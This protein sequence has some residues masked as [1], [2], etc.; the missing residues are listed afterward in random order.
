[1][2]T[3]LERIAEIAKNSPKEKFTSLIHLINK[4]MLI[5]CHN[6]LSG[7]KATGVDKLTKK[8]YEMNL[9]GNIE[10]LIARMK[11]FKY[12]PQ[13]VRRVYIDKPGSNKKRPLGI[14][15]HEDKIVQLAINKIL[16][17][18]YEQDFIDS[19]FGFRPN[20]SCHDAL[21]ILNVYLSEKDINY[22]VD[23]DIK[24]FFDNVDH[25][26]MMKFLEH[27]ISDKN[28]LRY[29]GR[30]L[31]TGIMENGTYHKVEEGT[32]Q[33]GIISPTLANIYL[34]YVLD[35]WFNNFI[36]KRCKGQAYIV[37]Y[38]DDFV[39]CFQ[40]ENEA[41][42]FYE[43]LKK[44][45]DKFNLQVAE[46]KTKILYFGKKSFYDRKFKRVWKLEDYTDRTF[47]FLGFTHYCSTRKDGSFRVK[48]KTSSKKFRAS[49]KKMSEWLKSNRTLPL[50]LLMKKLKQ[51]LIG[52]YRYYG[53]T[54][55]SRELKKFR[56]YVKKLTFKWLNKRSQ[57]RSYTW[58]NFDK[59]FKF[60]DIPEA[61]IYVNIFGLRKDIAYIL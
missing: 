10:N 3:K 34:H 36:K 11:A 54:D 37:R 16:Q 40:F 51:K 42:A 15:A 22:V 52:H 18:I 9:E 48:R 43:V 21:K 60:F 32:P 45:L 41:K 57:K 12:R 8:E 46:D 14:P 23:A 61:K 26:W 53:I 28:L 56:Y 58:V 33:G 13:P 2:Y 25:K 49:I 17:S 31:K 55:N 38:A 19:S 20:R 29:I 1:M 4:E 6:E 27:R 24:G 39:C 35:I 5:E 47:D 50:T 59:M 44:R 7:N 30:F